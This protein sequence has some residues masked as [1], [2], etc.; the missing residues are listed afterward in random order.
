MSTVAALLTRDHDGKPLTAPLHN[1]DRFT[2]SEF[3]R[4]YLAYPEDVKF[5][6]ICGIVYMASPLG[7]PHGTHHLELG[8]LLTLYK[9]ATP[10]V[11]AGDNA[12]I[13]LGEDSEPQPDLMLRILPAFGGQSRTTDD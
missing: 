11:E 10:G 2:Q 8:T 12:T 13:I 7:L 1:G 9:G 3:H 6:L 4:R 5:E